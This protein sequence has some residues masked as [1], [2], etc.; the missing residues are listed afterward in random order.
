MPVYGRGWRAYKISCSL[1]TLTILAQND[2]IT[3]QK[4]SYTVAMDFFGFFENS[5]SY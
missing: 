4:C 3:F 5:V 2:K 1:D